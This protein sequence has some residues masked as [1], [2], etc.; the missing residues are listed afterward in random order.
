M[1]YSTRRATHLDREQ[2]LALYLRVAKVSGGLARRVEEIDQNFIDQL[3]SECT[4]SGLILVLCTNHSRQIIG[5]IHA[6]G[7]VVQ[8]LNH[9][10]GNLTFLIEP[11]LQRQGHGKRLFLSFLKIIENELPQFYR[12]E[13]RA[14]ASNVRALCLYESIGFER[15]GLFRARIRSRE[16]EL[17]DGIPMVWFNHK[18]MV[19]PSLTDL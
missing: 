16:G 12:V 1:M 13:L 18:A 10:I 11:N 3:M 5:V 6:A 15:E 7:N 2:I 9:V 4:H 17:E 14:R 19:H 8:D